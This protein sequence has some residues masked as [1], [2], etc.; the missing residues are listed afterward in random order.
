MNPEPNERQK[1]TS[2]AASRVRDCAARTSWPFA[3]A[4][5]GPD[6]RLGRRVAGADR[7]LAERGQR[8]FPRDRPDQQVDTGLRRLG[9]PRHRGELKARAD[10]HPT[11]SGH[12]LVRQYTDRP[13]VHESDSGRAA[14]HDPSDSVV[15]M[16]TRRTVLALSD[17]RAPE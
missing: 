8:N 11:G 1:R 16:S 17:A 15:L 2:R 6:S 13:A 3:G 12:G 10:G 5:R 4:E 14:G 9:A 7:N